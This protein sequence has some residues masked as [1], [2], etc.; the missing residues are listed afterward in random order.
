MNCV[1]AL[2]RLKLELFGSDI[3][4]YNLVPSYMVELND[5]GHETK[6]EIVDYEFVRLCVIFREGCN[7]YEPYRERGAAVVGTFPK[8]SIGGV[9]LV[10]CFLDEHK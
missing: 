2:K 4:Q 3:D 7:L 5:R 9:L 1:H 10:A 6:L 8:T